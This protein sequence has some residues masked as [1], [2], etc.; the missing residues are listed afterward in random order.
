MNCNEAS[1]LV[2]EYVDDELDGLRRH[3]VEKHV[4]DC[5]SCAARHE[6]VLALRARLRTEIPRFPASPA[7][8]ARV[9]A[10]I[11]AAATP[12]SA[13]RAAPRE[14]WRWLTGGALAG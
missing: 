14:R 4:R 10:S 9:L 13:R 6:S 12:V 5:R 7:L 2:N 3:A 11:E 8:R 1:N